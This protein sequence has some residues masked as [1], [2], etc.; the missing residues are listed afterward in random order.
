MK[1]PVWAAAVGNG[2]EGKDQSKQEQ[3]C[4]GAKGSSCKGG[5][6]HIWQQA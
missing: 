4:R 1:D 6:S 3:A 5:A 2:L